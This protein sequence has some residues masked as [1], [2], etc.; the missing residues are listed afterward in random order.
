MKKKSRRVLVII[1]FLLCLCIGVLIVAFHSMRLEKIGYRNGEYK[2][3]ETHIKI[4]ESEC[5]GI[6]NIEDL[7]DKCGKI[8]CNQ[9]T[10]KFHNDL[11]HGEA[12]CVGYA[13]FHAA[14]LNYA[15]RINNLSHKARPTYGKAYLC[16]IDLHPLFKSIVP[17]KYEPFFKDHDYTEI[18]LGDEIL[19]VDTSI[20]D[21]L[22]Y[23]YFVRQRR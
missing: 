4:I 2:F 13:K 3:T 15:F 21:L 16:G 17:K 20:Q 12:N 8:V 11:N 1:G 6:T 22:S 19:Y 5:A 14:V 10:F 7:I 9:L 23:K 18:D